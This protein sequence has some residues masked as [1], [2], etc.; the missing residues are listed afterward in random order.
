MSGGFDCPDYYAEHCFLVSVPRTVTDPVAFQEVFGQQP[1]AVEGG[2]GAPECVLRAVLARDKWNLIAREVRLEFNRRLKADGKKAGRWLTGSNGVQRLLGKEL[3]VL[4]WAVEQD[5]VGE[6]ATLVAVR[7]WLGLKPEE[8]WWLYTMTAAV[9]GYASQKGLAGLAPCAASCV[10]LRNRS[11]CRQ[12]GHCDRAGAVAAKV[13]NT[14]EIPRV[15]PLSEYK[16]FFNK[17]K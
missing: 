6:E 7:N 2:D 9:T 11:G 12:S 8:R 5:E 4:V 16:I 1:A 17:I 3:L 13:G 15:K 14:E 10:D